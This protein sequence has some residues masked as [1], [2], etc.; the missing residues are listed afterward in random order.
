M[1]DLSCHTRI[2][3]VRYEYIVYLYRY[4]IAFD[5]S[6]VACRFVACRVTTAVTAVIRSYPFSVVPGSRLSTRTSTGILEV[7]RITLQPS[8]QSPDY[9]YIQKYPI[10]FTRTS[11]LSNPYYKYCTGTGTGTTIAIPVP[12]HVRYRWLY[13]T[14]VVL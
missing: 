3:Q 13:C 12:V 10:L 8:V 7:V 11:V 5:P 9:L 6:L 14:T 2:V 4:I 1:E